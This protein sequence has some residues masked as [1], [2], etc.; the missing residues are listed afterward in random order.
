MEV[1]AYMQIHSFV[2]ANATPIA[3]LAVKGIFLCVCM[4]SFSDSK[5]YGYLKIQKQTK[6]M[7]LL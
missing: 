1:I 4:Q 7:S 2:P 5:K 6:M 3:L